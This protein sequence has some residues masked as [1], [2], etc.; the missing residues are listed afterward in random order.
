M[1]GQTLEGVAWKDCGI[2]VLGEIQ[3]FSECGLEQP[4]LSWLD[5]QKRLC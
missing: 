4:D 2:S 3:N 1:V 5:F